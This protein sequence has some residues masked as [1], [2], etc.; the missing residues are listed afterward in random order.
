MRKSIEAIKGDKLQ[1]IRNNKIY[2][3]A[4]NAGSGLILIDAE[5]LL[6]KHYTMSNIKRWFK[7]VEEYVAPVEPVEP[8]QPSTD[9]SLTMHKISELAISLGLTAKTNSDHFVLKYNGK[10]VMEVRES[11]KHFRL[12]VRRACLTEDEQA[13]FNL[14]NKAKVVG[15]G[16]YVLDYKLE[17]ADF[18]TFR[19]VLEA[20]VQYQ[21]NKTR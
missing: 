10:N 16:T 7:V 4:D 21:I 6:A 17:T 3:V 20:A 15:N 11:K 9:N 2:E 8:V 13:N 18:R 12:V 14:H 1:N 5:T 19:Q